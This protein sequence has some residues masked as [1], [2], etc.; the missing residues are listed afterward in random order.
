MVRESF[1][2]FLKTRGLRFTRERG[3]IL[4]EVLSHEGHFEP[5]GLFVS[6]RNGGKKV[7]RA[8]IYRTLPLMAKAGIV[9]QV[10]HTDKQSH[11]E[12]TVGRGHHDHMRCLS[13]GKIIEF[14]SSDM[15]RLQEQV[16]GDQGFQVVG[17]VLEI[18]GYCK[19]CTSDRDTG[20]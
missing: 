11:Y 15:E 20:E 17:H 7:S 10:E 18:T 4:D 5:E 8:S 9:E 3:T 1:R 13:C 2:V 6:M 19:D 14:Y 12:C 16:C